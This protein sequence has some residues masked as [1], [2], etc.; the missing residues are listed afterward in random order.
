[1]EYE[2]ALN[3]GKPIIAFLHAQPEK[4]ESGKTEKTE[5]GRKKLEAFREIAK[6]KMVRNFLS[7]KELGSV[8][9]RSIIQ[10]IKTKPGIGWVRSNETVD[11]RG[12]QEILRLR[13][14]IERMEKELQN[15]ATISPPGSE[16][17]AQG[18]DEHSFGFE[19]TFNRNGQSWSAILGVALSWNQIFYDVSPRLDQGDAS[20]EQIVE[21]LIHATRFTVP[22]LVEKEYSGA[23]NIEITGLKQTSFQTILTQFKALGLIS[24]NEASKT[25]GRSWKL[26]PLGESKMNALFA[27]PS[28]MNSKPKSGTHIPKKKTAS[29]KASSK[30]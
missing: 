22:K 3:N 28:K 27:I 24:R 26:T 16:D 21:T 4:I 10:L 25:K 13:E 9:S 12:A 17:L 19:A 2:Y 18:A 29:G 20:D 11:G 23:T 30:L 1:M 6:K 14:Q 8:V 7:P 15:V 5:D